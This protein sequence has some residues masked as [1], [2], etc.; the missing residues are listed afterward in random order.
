[1]L[2]PVFALDSGSRSSCSMLWL[3]LLTPRWPGHRADRVL[4]TPGAFWSRWAWQLCLLCYQLPTHKDTAAQAHSWTLTVTCVLGTDS[5]RDG[6]GWWQTQPV[7]A[8]AVP[9]GPWQLLLR[10]CSAHL[11]CR[12]RQTWNSS[13][14][15]TQLT[16]FWVI[17]GKGLVYKL[18]EI[19]LSITDNYRSFPN[20]RKE[21]KLEFLLE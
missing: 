15:T 20:L 7:W 10:I 16:A 2:E 11:T 3:V 6:T 18:M 14:E 9:S 1:M 19:I 12:W 17:T 13:A 21:T 8:L 5:P 4:C